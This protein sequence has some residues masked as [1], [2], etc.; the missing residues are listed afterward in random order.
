MNSPLVRHV[1]A[2]LNRYNMRLGPQFAAAITYF[3]ILSMVPVLMFF[4][5]ATGFTLTVLRP[6]LWDAA[7]AA[8]MDAL[9]SGDEPDSPVS[10]IVTAVEG[11]LQGWR[12]FGLIAVLTAGYTGSNWVGN[13]KRAFRVMWRDKFSEAAEKRNFALE[14]LENLIIF[15]GLLI[16]IV[17][18]FGATV[19][20]VGFS[21]EIITWLGLGE[22]TGIGLIIRAITIALTFVAGWLLF[23]F[24]FI[25][26]PGERPDKRGFIGGTLAGA[27]IVTVIQQAAGLIFGAFSGNAAISVF[28][29]VIILMLVFNTL[30]TLIL[31]ISA[32]VGTADTYEEELARAEQAKRTGKTMDVDEDEP[33]TI[34]AVAA[35]QE[36]AKLEREKAQRWAATRSYD[37]L[38]AANFDPAEVPEPDP[39]VQVSQATAARG[40]KIASGVGYG[41]GTATGL[42]LGALLVN[43]FRRRR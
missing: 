19:V 36:Q 3:S 1:M 33:E 41:L 20:G 18:A 7:Q 21:E 23:A 32:W 40:M 6:E 4:I 2:A 39:E 5:A 15:V 12:S 9:P 10:G 13:L 30:A 25:A 11:M 35:S 34:P 14:L 27:F 43:L 42:G 29:P 22:V 26:L 38:R 28:G 17:I 31:M 24:I 8:I 16:C 37:S